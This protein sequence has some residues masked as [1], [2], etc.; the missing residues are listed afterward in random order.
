MPGT[1]ARRRTPS[2][3]QVEDDRPDRAAHRASRASSPGVMLAIATSWVNPA[4]VLIL[5]GHPR[6]Q[7]ESLRRQPAV[8]PL[9]MVRS[10][11]RPR[12][13]GNVWGAALTLVILVR[14]SASAPRSSRVFSP[15]S[16]GHQPASPASPRTDRSLRKRLDIKDLNIY[17]GGFPPSG[18]EPGG[19]TTQHHGLHRTVGLRQIDGP[20]HPSTA[21]TRSRPR[22]RGRQRAARR[23]DIYA[24][25]VDPVSVRATIGIW[26]SSG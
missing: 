7:L 25:D 9:M 13:F 5:V 21:C 17:Y 4:P 14:S 8:M 11:A 23:E 15:N 18:R 26:C 22:L 6:H 10:A 20:T 1:C 12:I 3:S 24:R 16:R 2:A 19:S